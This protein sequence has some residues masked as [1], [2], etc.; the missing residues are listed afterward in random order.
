M[1]RRV[2]AVALLLFLFAA[3]GRQA[4]PGVVESERVTEHSVA[5]LPEPP[6]APVNAEAIA[7]P[8]R[9]AEIRWLDDSD[10][11]EGFRVYRGTALVGTVGPDINRFQD[12]G[13]QEGVTY[14][15]AVRAFNQSGESPAA[16]CAVTMPAPPNTPSNL[17]GA[18]ISRSHVQL[19]WLDNSDDEEGFRVYR[20]GLLVGYVNADVTSYDD[21][22]LRAATSYQYAVVA[23]NQTG[24]SQSSTA[25]IRTRN[26]SIVL[27]L[28]RIG[29]YENHEPLLRGKGEVYLLVAIID[30]DHSTV[31]RYPSGE[32]ETYK[33]DKNETMVVGITVYSAEEVGDVLTVAFMGFEQDGQAFEQAAYQAL[34]GVAQWAADRYLSGLG[35]A[36]VGLLEMF[37]ISLA[38]WA[39]NLL[40]QQDDPLGSY[41]FTLDQSNNWGAGESAALVL[42]DEDGVDCLRLWFTIE[43]PE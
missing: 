4:T 35:T 7:I 10:N 5:I 22:G 23:Y 15:Y 24:D 43:N 32:G 27:R 6:R 11:E 12:V 36:A 31:L 8:Q 42:Q 39:G 21:G 30:G 38:E 37:D 1:I 18:A 26:P 13:L 41:E 19:L 14:R 3:C 16:L 29:V 2:V 17:E 20:D 9:T 33:L 40:G 25:G 28:D 34:E